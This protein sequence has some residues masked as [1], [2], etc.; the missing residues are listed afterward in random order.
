MET[1]RHSIN[2]PIRVFAATTKKI[3]VVSTEDK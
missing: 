1:F 2:N 3:Y